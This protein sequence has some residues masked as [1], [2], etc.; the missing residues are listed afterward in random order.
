MPLRIVTWNVNSVRQRM[1]HLERFCRLYEPDVMC[2]QEIKVPSD[3]FP[4]AEVAAF[5]YPHVE[6]HGQKGYNGVARS[7][8]HTSELQSLMRISYAVFCLKKKKHNTRLLQHIHNYT[9]Y[10]LHSQDKD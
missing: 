3:D 4:A 6:V 8:E 5:G 7:E 9:W 1:A 2:L 10:E